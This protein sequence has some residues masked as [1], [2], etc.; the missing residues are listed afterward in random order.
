MRMKTCK[1]KKVTRFSSS[2]P[3]SEHQ[4]RTQH[5]DIKSYSANIKNFLLYPRFTLV[6]KNFYKMN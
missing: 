2:V 3:S 5:M 4:I 1:R 6:Q